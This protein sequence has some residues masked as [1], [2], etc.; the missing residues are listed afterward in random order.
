MKSLRS[1]LFFL[2]FITASPLFGQ[3]GIMVSVKGFKNEKGKAFIRITDPAGKIVETYEKNIVGKEV[4]IQLTSLK[5]GRY[6][7][8]VFHDEN[9]NQKLDTATLGYP[10]EPWGVSNNVRPKFRA[11]SLEE[12]LINVRKEQ[13]IQITVK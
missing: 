10:V 11:P 7:I 4:S 12:M 1:S 8:E 3:Q 13:A 6:A 2:L 5:E 9:N